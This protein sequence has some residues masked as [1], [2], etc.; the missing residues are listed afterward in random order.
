[1]RG[2]GSTCKSPHL[3]I[4]LML[5]CII[6]G[7]CTSLRNADGLLA[8]W[9]TLTLPA[10]RRGLERVI[11]FCDVAVAA[12][13]ECSKTLKRHVCRTPN[14]GGKPIIHIL[15][16]LHYQHFVFQNPGIDPSTFDQEPG[17][18]SYLTTG[19]RAGF[20]WRKVACL[21]YVALHAQGSMDYM[22]LKRYGCTLRLLGGVLPGPCLV[23]N[24][25]C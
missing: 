17:A 8:G 7:C 9:F 13:M 4:F 12:G 15:L 21:H 10:Q 11:R 24:P 16:S 3:S 6:R 14:R 1:M 5:V 18:A 22:T 2:R 20:P 19:R 23:I 25:T